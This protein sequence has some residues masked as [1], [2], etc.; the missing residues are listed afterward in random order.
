MNR[1]ECLLK[2][3]SQVSVVFFHDEGTENKALNFGFSSREVSL[4]CRSGQKKVEINLMHR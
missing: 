3:L 4:S 1:L 2:A